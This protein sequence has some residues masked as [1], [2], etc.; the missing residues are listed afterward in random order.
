MMQS[1][2]SSLSPALAFQPGS[3]IDSIAYSAPEPV[4]LPS[5]PSV[6]PAEGAEPIQLER[7]YSLHSLEDFIQQR[8]ALDVWDSSILSPSR[9]RAMLAETVSHA[10]RLA[11]ADRNRARSLGK[12]TAVLDEQDELCRL[13]QLY[14]SALFKG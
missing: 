4:R 2:R 8:L 11:R 9:F 7:L 5:S 6:Q 10:R 3:G 14:M 12:L 1:Q 13:A